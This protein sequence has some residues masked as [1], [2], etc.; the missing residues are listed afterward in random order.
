MSSSVKLAFS[1]RGMSC[2]VREFLKSVLSLPDVDAMLVQQWLP[3]NGSVMPALVVNPELLD[4][5]SPLMPV[6]MMNAAGLVSRLTMRPSGGRVAVVLRNCEIRAF[7]ELVKLKQGLLDELLIIGFDCP[8]VMDKSY[9]PESISDQEERERYTDR[10][11]QVFNTGNQEQDLARA[12][13]ICEHP[14]P[15]KGDLRIALAQNK[16]GD[17]MPLTAFSEEGEKILE[18]LGYEAW[19]SAHLENDAWISMVQSRKAARDECFEDAGQKTGSIKKLAEYFS[20]CINCYNCRNVC[21]VCYCKACVFNTDTFDH[22]PF[23]YMNW[24]GR[25]GILKMPTDT[26]FYHLT[27][28]A[29][30]STSCVGCGQCSYACPQNIPVMELFRSVARDTQKAFDYEA[31]RDWDEPLP[32]AAFREDEFQGITG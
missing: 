27:R 32:S 7:V 4:D 29:H 14:I 13:K 24:A 22:D 16:E 31:G 3:V 10:F 21:P 5:A 1:G 19:D 15:L 28:L 9:V 20:S 11:C 6:F 12:C 23:Q 26:I 25:K 30:M 18:R 8:G 17:G 2:A